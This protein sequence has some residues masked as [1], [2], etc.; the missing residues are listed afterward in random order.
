MNN[1][2][3]H[4]MTCTPTGYTHTHT[5]THIVSSDIHKKREHQFA[6]PKAQL[7]SR[8]AHNA[9]TPTPCMSHA[10]AHTHVK[11]IRQNMKADPGHLYIDWRLTVLIFSDFMVLSNIYINQK[12]TLK[13][14][15][16]C[17]TLFIAYWYIPSIF[18][19]IFRI[20][21]TSTVV[22]DDEKKA[23]LPHAQKIL[24]AFRSCRVEHVG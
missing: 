16:H 23:S 12:L 15:E 21:H 5:H 3:A 11:S 2:D 24:C 18:S 20:L 17:E 13:K 6:K 7:W 14:G 19:P 4:I 8:L 9:C 1:P 10:H 22:A